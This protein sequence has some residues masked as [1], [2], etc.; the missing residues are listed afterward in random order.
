MAV[1]EKSQACT[2]AC[3]LIWRIG[4]VVLPTPQP[5][6]RI[7]CNQYLQTMC[8]VDT[9]FPD[10]CTKS[11]GKTHMFPSRSAKIREIKRL[12]YKEGQG[13]MKSLQELPPILSGILA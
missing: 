12:L 2:N 4:K 3:G 5:T 9:P 10:P 7:S 1:A 11:Q 6:Y 13:S 8:S